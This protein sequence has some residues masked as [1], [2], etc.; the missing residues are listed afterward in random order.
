[1]YTKKYWYK[2]NED[3]VFKVGQEFTYKNGLI[4]TEKLWDKVDNGTIIVYET[5]YIYDEH[6][7][8]LRIL[9]KNSY[10]RKVFY[11]Y[12]DF[13]LPMEQITINMDRLTITKFRYW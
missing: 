4:Q 13:G 10:Q 12:F 8:L 6:N 7:R 1:M 9:N 3:T 11:T 5:K 2:L